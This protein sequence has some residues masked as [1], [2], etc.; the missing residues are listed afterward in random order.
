MNAVIIRDVNIPLSVDEFS[1]EFKY[2]AK[3]LP[4]PKIPKDFPPLSIGQGLFNSEGDDYE[5][6]NGPEDGK[7]MN[8]TEQGGGDS[9]SG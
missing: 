2:V 1:E 9:R 5:D 3:G 8:F 7:R 4:M 6:G